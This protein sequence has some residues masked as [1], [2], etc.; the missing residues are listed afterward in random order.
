M[1]RN[2]RIKNSRL[3]LGLALAFYGLMV[4]L[5]LA[6]EVVSL[7]GKWTFAMDIN[8]EGLHK[9]WFLGN[10]TDEIFLPGTTDL[11]GWGTPDQSPWINYLQRRHKYIGPVWYQKTVDIPSGWNGY[12]TDLF[13]ERVK[14]ESRVW[15]DGKEFSR[16]DDGLVVSHTHNL[17]VLSPGKHTICIRVDNRMIHPI[18]DKG[19]NYTEQTESIWNGIVGKIELRRRNVVSLNR[20]RLFAEGSK[21]AVL[22]DVSLDNPTKAPCQAEV[23]IVLKDSTQKIIGRVSVKKMLA[24]SE[25]ANYAINIPVAKLKTWSEFQQPLYKAFCTISSCGQ[26]ETAS[27]VTFAFRTLTT[28]RYKILVNNVPAF[29]RGSQECLGNPSEGHPPM[30]VESW[31]RIFKIYKAHGLNQV[32]FHSGCPPEAAFQAADQLGIYLMVELVWMT[33]INAKPDLRPISA[34]MGM[35]KGIGNNDRTIDSFV[36]KETKR[37]LNQYGNH[38]SFCFFAFGNEMDN[39]NREAVNKWLE[40]FKR[41]DPRHLYAGTT[42]RMVLSN[43]DFQESHIVPGKGSIVN[44]AGNPSTL[45]GYDSAY[46]YTKVPVIAHELGQYPVYP[47]W[48][49]IA[50]YATTPFRFINLEKSLVLAKENHIDGQAEDFRKSSGYLQQLLYKEDI[51]REFRSRYSAGF[52]LLAMVDYTGQ[53]EALVGWL[54]AFYKSKGI[55]T[56]EQFSRFCNRVVPLAQ[57]SK[58][59][60]KNTETLQVVFQ[61]ACNTQASLKTGLKWQLIRK[62]D[63]RMVSAGSF[64]PHILIPGTVTDFGSASIKFPVVDEAV[65]YKLQLSATN[66]EYANDWDFW[67]YPDQ[68]SADPGKPGLKICDNITDAIALAAAGNK[69]LFMANNAGDPLQKDLSGFMPVFWSTIFFPGTGTKTLSALVQYEHPALKEFPTTSSLDWQWEEVCRNSRGTILDGEGIDIKPIVQPIDDF[70]TNR[71]LASIFEVKSGAGS[72]LICGYNLVDKLEERPAARQLRKSLLDYISTE[73][74]SPAITVSDQ[75]LRNKFYAV[76]TVPEKPDLTGLDKMVFS[77]LPGQNSKGSGNV[78]DK[79]M[80]E[81]VANTANMNWKLAK[82]GIADTPKTGWSTKNG[83]VLK[84]E[85]FTPTTT[86][87]FVNLQIQAYTDKIARVTVIVDG[88]KNTFNIGKTGQWI[89]LQYFREDFDDNKLA[90]EIL[91]ADG[92]PD[93][94]VS[95]I[96]VIKE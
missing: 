55:T 90:I 63:G 45:T 75:W 70:H 24:A 61:L 34:T 32:R 17:G 85:L 91:P 10:M 53:G 26:T 1:N 28:S 41:D 82:G 21:K 18:G 38:P 86:I 22:A 14:W 31:M 20:L 88:R 37:L 96:Q 12:R 50:R 42:A 8:D 65:A 40:E 58:R 7:Q 68:P 87:G 13:L 69:V 3:K 30:D 54:D 36:V 6:Q 33:S 78:W 52:N 67:T 47:S 59:V 92:D 80:D 46:V 9:K 84:F 73:D 35:P 79:K 66:G 44:K 89:K 11:A 4:N 19:H 23:N 16:P 5:S 48:A 74:F 76:K 64:A 49:E 60:Y 72:I 83:H 57:F 25:T 77:L 93:V 2:F 43:D 39:L 95:K 27:P 51:E 94:M 71:K 62:G 81:V 56:P 15:V 29:I